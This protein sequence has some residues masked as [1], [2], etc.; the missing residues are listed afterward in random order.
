MEKEIR[1]YGIN[2]EELKEEF[3]DAVE[4]IGWG[5][6]ANWEFIEW[7]TEQGNVWS[8]KGFEEAFNGVEICTDMF[9]IRII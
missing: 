4:I 5:K 7:A 1:V 8:L 6:I 9:V 2:Q 3:L